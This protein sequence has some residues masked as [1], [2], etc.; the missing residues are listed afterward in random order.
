MCASVCL[1]LCVY[2][3]CVWEPTRAKDLLWVLGIKLDSTG[4]KGLLSL[5]HQYISP[6]MRIFFM[7]F[8]SV[9]QTVTFKIKYSNTI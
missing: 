4:N 6:N 9:I 1:C 3:I 2:A 7:K 5:Y 8:K